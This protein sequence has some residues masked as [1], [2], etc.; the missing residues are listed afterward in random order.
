MKC[1]AGHVHF[2]LSI[3]AKNSDKLGAVA[4]S[5]HSFDLKPV[6]TTN[7]AFKLDRCIRAD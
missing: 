4:F 3:P 2:E 1:F 5:Q 7:R 6:E